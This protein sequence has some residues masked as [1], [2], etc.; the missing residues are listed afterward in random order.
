MPKRQFQ[1]TFSIWNIVRSRIT[2]SVKMYAEMLDLNISIHCWWFDVV[3]SVNREEKETEKFLE[4]PAQF[5][6]AVQ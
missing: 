5:W 3:E 1:L 2:I 4:C 6:L